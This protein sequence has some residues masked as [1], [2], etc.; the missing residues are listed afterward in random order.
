MSHERQL[1]SETEIEQEKVDATT[2]GGKAMNVTRDVINDLWPVYAAGEA[3]ADTRALIEEFLDRDPEFAQLVRGAADKAL[4]EHDVPKLPL[5]H[6]AQ[7]LRK[8]KRLLQ[9]WDW[10]LFLAMLFSGFAFGRI[11]SDTSW[12][13]SPVNFIVMASIAGCF[14]IAFF[15][16]LVLVRKRVYSGGRSR[17]A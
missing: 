8:T 12:D 6:E 5:D 2:V 4:L 17:A 1:R 7:A 3:S 15:A 11:I 9:G 10:T 13:V 16:R 14:W